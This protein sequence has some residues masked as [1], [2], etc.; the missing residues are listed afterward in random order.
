MH[1]N[2]SIERD[3]WEWSVSGPYERSPLEGSGW[4]REHRLTTLGHLHTK[5]QYQDKQIL[6]WHIPCPTPTKQPTLSQ[7]H[8]VT[9][10]NPHLV[11]RRRFANACTR[12]SFVHQTTSKAPARGGQV[13]VVVAHPKQLIE[14]T[15]RHK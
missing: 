2:I 10:S 5:S 11:T 3:N 7:Y 15:H 14:Q 13:T 9:Y 12:G 8:V 4:K 1:L 6:N